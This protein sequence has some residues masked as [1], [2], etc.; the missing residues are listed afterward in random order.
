[1]IKNIMINEIKIRFN[2]KITQ[3]HDPMNTSWE[4]RGE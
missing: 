1:M 3:V 4:K 2:S